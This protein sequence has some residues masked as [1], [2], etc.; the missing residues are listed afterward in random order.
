MLHTVRWFF[1]SYTFSRICM[2][3]SHDLNL[4]TTEA[5][6]Y[7]TTHRINCIKNQLLRE[8]TLWPYVQSQLLMTKIH[9][10]LLEE[11]GDTI[12]Q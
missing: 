1:K 8:N 4:Q 7:M 6:I 2:T 3:H 10:S 9:L 11:A 12:N 5:T